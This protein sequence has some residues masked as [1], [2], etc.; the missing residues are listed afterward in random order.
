MSTRK[1]KTEP[2]VTPHENT[3]ELAT[4]QLAEPAPEPAPADVTEGAELVDS[5][6]EVTPPADVAEPTHY[7]VAATKRR[8]RWRAGR[9]WAPEPT[10]VARDEL[11]AVAWALVIA[12]PA[13]TVTP[14]A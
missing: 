5:P 13:L 12:D 3:A 7:L 14:E 1:P 4:E 9:F 10:R 8:G 6:A 2:A 11:D